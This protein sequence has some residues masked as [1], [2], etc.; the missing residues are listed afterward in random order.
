MDRTETGLESVK[1]TDQIAHL[2][3][4]VRPQDASPVLTA[5]QPG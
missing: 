2:A 5:N 4:E 3:R 1:K